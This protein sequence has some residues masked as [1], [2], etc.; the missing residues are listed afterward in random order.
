MSW[1]LRNTRL[2]NGI[3]ITGPIVRST[4]KQDFAT[5]TISHLAPTF[6]D[7][8]QLNDNPHNLLLITARSLSA[9]V[10]TRA[11]RARDQW[12]DFEE[13]NALATDA[14]FLA[15]LAHDLPK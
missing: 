6:N 3:M 4:A 12:L 5:F 14:D 7:R 15:A 9:F 1:A 13:R 10:S 8:G 11:A 2:P